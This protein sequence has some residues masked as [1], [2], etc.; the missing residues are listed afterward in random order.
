MK[1][2][3]KE[4][5]ADSWKMTSGNY[6]IWWFIESHG[7]GWMVGFEEDIGTD[8][9][10]IYKWVDPKSILPNAGP[11]AGNANDWLYSDRIADCLL[12]NLDRKAVTQKGE[13]KVELECTGK[14]I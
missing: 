11:Y 7:T 2:K 3:K 13:I 1:S 4:N 5:G 14:L 9:G 10:A 6:T 8:K 12:C